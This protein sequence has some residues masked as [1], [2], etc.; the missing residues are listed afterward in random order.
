LPLRGCRLP[1]LHLQ[2]R[3]RPSLGLM[4]QCR[5]DRTSLERIRL[6]DLHRPGQDLHASPR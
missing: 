4:R 1:K 6:P 3:P 2:H 5:H